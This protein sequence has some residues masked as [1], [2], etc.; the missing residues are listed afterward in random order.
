MTSPRQLLAAWNL[1]ARKELGQNFLKDPSC[2]EMIAARA[3]LGPQETVLEIGA[4][5][6]AL[7]IPVARRVGKVY[8]VE[9]DPNLAR[10]LSTEILVAGLANVS[11][12]Q[13]DILKIDM[14]ALAVEAG[15]KLT[16][17]GNLPYNISSQV[18]VLLIQGRCAVRRA[19]LM[20]QKELAERISAGPGCKAY[21]R[22]TVMLAYCADVAAIADVPA[23]HFHPRPKVD[24]R[25][26]E[27]HFKPAPDY[28]AQN[29]ALLFKV[30]KAAFGKRRKTL[31]NALCGSELGLKPDEAEQL[32]RK[33]RID[34][35]RR[36][37]TLHISEFVILCNCLWDWDRQKMNRLPEL[38]PK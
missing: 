17:L 16:V 38:I 18:L 19:V 35:M 36:A 20:F 23:A 27:I 33:S 31:K 24:S 32:L 3:N 1:R 21:G 15:E 25:V 34:P 14:A 13:D 10:L 7:T 11:V 30:V 22:L 29:E 37:E 9:R 5:L 6:G 8:A 2:A 28:P 12:L 4:G 26:I